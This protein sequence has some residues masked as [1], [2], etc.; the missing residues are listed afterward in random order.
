MGRY[1]K[2]TGQELVST[3]EAAEHIGVS[4]IT[5]RRWLADGSFQSW[6][7]SEKK[8]PLE[9]IELSNGK[10]VWQFNNRNRADL[11][12][13][14]DLPERRQRGATGR[15]EAR[16]EK[17]AHKNFKRMYG[18]KVGPEEQKRNALIR[19]YTKV[20][21]QLE[22]GGLRPKNPKLLGV[23]RR[24]ISEAAVW[25]DIYPFLPKSL[26]LGAKT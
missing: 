4:Y 21:V 14:R 26:A 24:H 15:P 7:A 10:H 17:N 1:N 18:T 23:P 20:L 12:D 3:S 11:R 16:R 2:Q 5:L 13:Y 19:R 9:S 25:R 8:P 6:L 22:N